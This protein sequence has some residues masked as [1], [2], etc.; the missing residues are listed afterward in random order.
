MDAKASMLK[1]AQSELA[2]AQYSQNSP[3]VN[4][5]PLSVMMRL[6]TPKRQTSSQ[7]NLTAELAGIVHTGSTSTHLVNLSMAT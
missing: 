3:L 4:W 6:G 2:D 1:R 5:L 7:I